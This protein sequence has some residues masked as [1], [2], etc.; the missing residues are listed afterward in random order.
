M[1]RQS[2]R[3]GAGDAR[4]PRIVSVCVRGRKAVNDRTNHRSLMLLEEVVEALTSRPDWHPIDAVV[5][6]GGFF[7]LHHNLGPLSFAKRAASI[8]RT[9]IGRYCQQSA[10]LLAEEFAGI[11]L[12]VGFD[13]DPVDSGN[14]GDQMCVAFQNDAVIGIGRKVF[15]VEGDVS[16]YH[17]P[18][19]CFIEDFGTPA[20]VITLANGS[21]A[22]L[23]ACYDVFGL[24]E[25]LM[26]PTARTRYIRHLIVDGRRISDGDPGFRAAREQAL[27]DWMD[28]QMSKGISVALAAIHR[29]RRPGRDIFWQ[30]H[31]I[32]SASA[33]IGGLCVG[34]AHFWN[35]LPRPE[36]RWASELAAHNVPQRHLLD[37]QTRQAHRHPPIGAIRLWLDDPNAPRLLLRLY[38]G[39]ESLLG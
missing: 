17:A 30:R 22:M 27:S 31:G 21:R 15:P 25:P 12:V 23:C 34:A 29:F 5:L 16:S 13:T 3:P 10:T 39:A 26:G 7:R 32:A 9:P 36:H 1:S 8:L 38:E 35:A 33:S 14:Y 2:R 37:A 24:V 18:L 4:P 6:P 28:L 19:V 20:R 11:A